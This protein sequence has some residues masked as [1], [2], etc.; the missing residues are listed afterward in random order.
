M[1]EASLQKGD[2]ILHLPMLTMGNAT[3]ALLWK[4]AHDCDIIGKLQVSIHS[5]TSD[6]RPSTAPLIGLSPIVPH[7][8][9]SASAFVWASHS[10]Q[11]VGSCRIEC[12][13]V[14]T[15]REAREAS[16][17]RA[18]CPRHQHPVVVWCRAWENAPMLQSQIQPHLRG[19]QVLLSWQLARLRGC[20]RP[21]SAIAPESL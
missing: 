17:A 13:H 15:I 1:G 14:I 3:S 2:C 4:R 8:I 10:L 7:S 5:G 12:V 9:E 6:G 16:P 18:G 20:P 21:L 19:L 11:K